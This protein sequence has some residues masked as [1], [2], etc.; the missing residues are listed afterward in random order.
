M[1]LQGLL[2]ITKNSIAKSMAETIHHQSENWN[3]KWNLLVALCM[4]IEKKFSC[5]MISK[6]TFGHHRIRDEKLWI[7]D[8][9]L[10]I[11]IKLVIESF[12][13]NTWMA[14]ETI[15]SPQDWWWKIFGCTSY[16]DEKFGHQSC[17]NWICF[18]CHTYWGKV[19]CNENCFPISLNKC[20]W[21]IKTHVNM[22]LDAKWSCHIG[23]DNPDFLELN[24]LNTTKF[25][26]KLWYMYFDWTKDWNFSMI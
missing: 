15:W 26:T 22:T 2:F 13:V 18:S 5:H 16:C 17:G 7:K 14:I 3:L 12:L 6:K 1:K 10:L 23:F 4:V 20:N 9:Q 24:D 11:T 25:I 19:G 8:K 21:R